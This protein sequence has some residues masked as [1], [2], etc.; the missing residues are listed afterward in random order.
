MVLIRF[1]EPRRGAKT[2]GGVR[3]EDEMV[4]VDRVLNDETGAS[5]RQL[6]AGLVERVDKLGKG[7]RA[8]PDA[9]EL[10]QRVHAPV[11]LR[12]LFLQGRLETLPSTTLQLVPLQ[13]PPI[14]RRLYDGVLH[15]V[16]VSR[17]SYRDRTLY[18]YHFVAGD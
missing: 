17:Y 10:V 9:V 16:T 7:H 6:V 14:S 11:G 1:W 15:S 13:L 8:L 4:L 3:V 5:R 12:E 18:I 2:E